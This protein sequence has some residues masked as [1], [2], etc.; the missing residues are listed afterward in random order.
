[1]FFKVSP[2]KILDTALVAANSET[3]EPVGGQ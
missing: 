3:T 2:K 1:M